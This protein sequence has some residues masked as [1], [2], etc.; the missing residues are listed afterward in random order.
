MAQ[1]AQAGAGFVARGQEHTYKKTKKKGAERTFFGMLMWT[2]C[3][4]GLP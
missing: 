1:Q 2:S 3:E 4:T